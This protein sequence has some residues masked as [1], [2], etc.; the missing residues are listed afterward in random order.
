MSIGGCHRSAASQ[1][2]GSRLT[3]L[4]GVVTPST[5]RRPWRSSP[6]CERSW[7]TTLASPPPGDGTGDR[8]QMT[9]WGRRVPLNPLLA[10]ATVLSGPPEPVGARFALSAKAISAMSNTKNSASATYDFIL[11]EVDVVRTGP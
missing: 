11:T 4:P 10:A 8:P 6:R 1:V 5:S 9:M 3:V 2:P 7:A